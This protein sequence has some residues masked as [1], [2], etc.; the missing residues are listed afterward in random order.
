MLSI[1]QEIGFHFQDE[2]PGYA[3][4]LS[5]SYELLYFD[6]PRHLLYHPNPTQKLLEKQILQI[7]G[8][9]ELEQRYELDDLCDSSFQE[10]VLKIQ[11]STDT[12]SGEKAIKLIDYLYSL[13]DSGTYEKRR[14]IRR[15]HVLVSK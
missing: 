3:L 7:A 8:V 9:P 10:Y 12:F 6:V 2:L 5:S 15:L 13:V 14:G 11:L 1:I 4:E